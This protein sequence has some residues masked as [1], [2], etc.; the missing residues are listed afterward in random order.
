MV[1]IL[2]YRISR[3]YSILHGVWGYLERNV[4]ITGGLYSGLFCDILNYF[5]CVCGSQFMVIIFGRSLREAVIPRP[6]LGSDINFS[7]VRGEDTAA[8]IETWAK[9]YHCFAKGKGL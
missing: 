3:S 6:R 4:S 2:S 8:S 9:K 7:N 5:P 1:F